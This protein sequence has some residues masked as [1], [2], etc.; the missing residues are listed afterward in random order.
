MTGCAR[1]RSRNISSR[2]D[3]LEAALHCVVA[4]SI[5]E[6]VARLSGGSEHLGGAMSLSQEDPREAPHLLMAEK[7]GELIRRCSSHPSLGEAPD[8]VDSD[9]TSATFEHC[10]ILYRV[11]HENGWRSVALVEHG[12]GMGVFETPIDTK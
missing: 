11:A 6:I 4:A 5:S 2:F 12:G 3:C 9:T 7:P 1:E 10:A 8:D